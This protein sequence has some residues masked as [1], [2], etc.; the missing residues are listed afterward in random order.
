MQTNILEYL[1]STAPRL[2]Q[3]VAYSDGTD[4]LTFDALYRSARAVGSALLQK[5]FSKEPIAILMKKH[6]KEIAAFYGT[7]YA[8]CF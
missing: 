5:G 8:G 6:P 3:K 4:D 7:V 1:E 2:P